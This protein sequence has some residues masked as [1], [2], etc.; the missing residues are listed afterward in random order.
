MKQ[1][2]IKGNFNS[3]IRRNYIDCDYLDKLSTKDK[4][5]VNRFYNEYYGAN[6]DN[7]N[8]IHPNPV[9]IKKEANKRIYQCRNDIHNMKKETL[10]KPLD[11]QIGQVISKK[12]NKKETK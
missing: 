8:P 1:S 2:K 12:P 11:Q 5:Y 6:V 7:T 4:E 10:T 3:Q 9:E